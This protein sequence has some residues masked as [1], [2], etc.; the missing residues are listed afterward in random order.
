[1]QVTGK[2]PASKADIA[3]NNDHIADADKKVEAAQTAE[4]TVAS[5]AAVRE[6][7][8]ESATN[9]TPEVKEA[10]EGKV[11]ADIT[12]VFPAEYYNK[13]AVLKVTPIMV[14]EGGIVEG[15]TKYCQGG[16]VNAN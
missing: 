3:T 11:E 13:K 1:M 5:E 16:K 2:L 14:F 15:A 9:E 7:E 6:V 8:A 12:V 4:P 10:P